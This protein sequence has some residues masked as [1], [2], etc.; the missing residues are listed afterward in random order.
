MSESVRTSLTG[1]LLGSAEFRRSRYGRPYLLFNLA[2]DPDD[3]GVTAHAGG[4]P[5]DVRVRL[6][7][8]EIADQLHEGVRVSLTGWLRLENQPG[9]DAARG[10]RLTM[11][12]QSCTVLSAR[13][14]ERPESDQGE[15]R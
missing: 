3:Q 7:G 4:R 2:V 6:Y 5:P 9:N 11:M 12:A 15:T 10:A 1:R 13:I 14:A 8:A